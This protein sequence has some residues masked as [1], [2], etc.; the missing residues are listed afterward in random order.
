MNSLLPRHPAGSSRRLRMLLQRCS[1]CGR[2]SEPYLTRPA[3]EHFRRS[4]KINT[5]AKTSS[6]FE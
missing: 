2:Y 3:N 5:V 4:A 6:T 1:D